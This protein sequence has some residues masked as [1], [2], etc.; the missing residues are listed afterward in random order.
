MLENLSKNEADKSAEM[1][2]FVVSSFGV[3]YV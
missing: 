1:L 2:A 3:R